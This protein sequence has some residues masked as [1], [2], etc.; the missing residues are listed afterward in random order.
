[1]NL[2]ETLITNETNILEQKR[3]EGELDVK[4]KTVHVLLYPPSF[5]DLFFLS[6]VFGSD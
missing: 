4:Y 3:I 5:I 1:M 6:L 2:D